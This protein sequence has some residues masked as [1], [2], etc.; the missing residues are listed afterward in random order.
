M[1]FNFNCSLK[2]DPSDTGHDLAGLYLG[3]LIWSEHSHLFECFVFLTKESVR[4]GN[5]VIVQHKYKKCFQHNSD[6][7]IAQLFHSASFFGISSSTQTHDD[8]QT[9]LIL[10]PMLHRKQPQH[11]AAQD[12]KTHPEG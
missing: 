11:N 10:M 12:N 4:R 1:Q 8:I 3:Y 7:I 9:F 6:L 2:T 5:C